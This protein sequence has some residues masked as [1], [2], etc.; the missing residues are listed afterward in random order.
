M[1]TTI[2][3]VNSVEY[4][5]VLEIPATEL[6]PFI[7]NKLRQVAKKATMPGF[8]PG[9][10]PKQLIK[11]LYGE[12]AAFEVVDK[13]VKDTFEDEVLDNPAYETFGQSKMT[14]F[15]YADGQDL[16]AVIRFGIYPQFELSTLE[17][18]QVSRLVNPVTPEDVQ[19]QLDYMLLRQSTL[20]DSDDAVG[21]KSILTTDMV[22]LDAETKEV[23]DSGRNEENAT[24]VMND[25]NLL[26]V[27]KAALLGKKSGDVVEVTVTHED[28]AHAH[29]HVWQ[30]TI[31]NIQERNIPELTDELA[32]KMSQEQAK[33]VEELKQILEK[34]ETSA[35]EK[36]SND[37]VDNKVISEALKANI[38]E[39]P[40]SVVESMLDHYV[41]TY[42]EE[43]LRKFNG[44]LPDSY[45][46]NHYRLSQTKNAEQAARWMVIRDKII[47]EQNF[48]IL[49]EDYQ[50]YYNEL[51]SALGFVDVDMIRSIFEQNN[52][53]AFVNEME[54]KILSQ[55]ALDFLKN[56]VA[57]V[58]KS[59]ADFE[60]EQAKEDL[61][62]L[63]GQEAKISAQ[64]TEL[65]EGGE[66]D[67]ARDLQKD[68]ASI[69]AEIEEM[70]QEL[71]NVS[72]E[73]GVK[74]E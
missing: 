68:L 35:R 25:P 29:S 49:D 24:I 10:V 12:A 31:K 45:N 62:Y 59:R 55:K 40:E 34:Q 20:E 48:D 42:R 64:V 66:E 74:A 65:Q 58:E 28:P 41:K 52:K 13:L 61:S 23:K 21:E 18:V 16:K 2:T 30:V 70:K 53:E 72:S 36:R 26:E 4:D 33:T 67:V 50:A 38:F 54:D 56:N 37:L 14:V 7:E 27:F 71:T 51:A 69:R 32:A 15:E 43:Q 3:P 9:K 73:A 17:G 5:F 39:V 57:V 11:K 22:E 1:N 46:E 47:E 19:G 60:K 6:T 8:R 44:K 63:E